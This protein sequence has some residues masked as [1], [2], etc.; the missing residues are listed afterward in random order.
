M[1]EAA[2]TAVRAP[3]DRCLV[4]ENH[5]AFL[6]AG[7]EAMLEIIPVPADGHRLISYPQLWRG[8]ADAYISLQF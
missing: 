3:R 1:V 8:I 2:A 7:G 6:R 5:R 4:R